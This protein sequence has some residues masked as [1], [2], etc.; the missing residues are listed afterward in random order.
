MDTPTFFAVA[1]IGFLSVN[2]VFGSELTVGK[3]SGLVKVRWTQGELTA[4]LETSATLENW[5]P[6]PVGQIVTDPAPD[7]RLYTV[8][9]PAG[10]RFF[11]LRLEDNSDPLSA[12]FED[13][14]DVSSPGLPPGWTSGSSSIGAGGTLWELGSPSSVGPS[15]ASS[16]P[17]CVGTDLDDQYEHNT[18]IWLRTPAIDLTETTFA[19][20]SFKRFRHIGANR[21]DGDAGSIRILAADN[22]EQLAL[23][24]TEV[25][26]AS[27]G[28]QDYSRELPPSAFAEPII[29]EFQFQSDATN[30]FWLGVENGGFEIPEDLGNGDFTYTA[31]GWNVSNGG[32]FDPDA[33]SGYPGG[34][35][36]EGENVAWV[37]NG[38][39]LTQNLGIQLSANTSY[40]LSTRIGTPNGNGGDRGTYR[41]ELRAGSEVIQSKQGAAPVGG[42]WQTQTIT[43]NSG[44]N[45]DQLDQDLEIRLLAVGNPEVNYDAVT[46]TITGEGAEAQADP[47]GWYLD[48]VQIRLETEGGWRV[49]TDSPVSPLWHHDDLFFIDDDTGWLCNISGEIWKT[50]DGG[51]SWTRVLSQPETAFRTIT[52]LD[53]MNGWV[54]NLGKG[55]WVGGVSD[56]NPLYETSDGGETW[57]AIPGNRISGPTPDGICGLWAV[58]ENTIHGTGR[59][60]GGAFFI[61]SRDGGATWVSRELSVDYRGFVDVF[62]HTPDVGYITGTDNSGDA[63][64]LYTADGGT[65]WTSAMSNNAIHYWKMGF[66]NETFGY[67]V[68]WSG[69]ESDRWIQT[70]DGGVTWTDRFFHSGVEA[71]GIGFV[72]EQTGWI[73]CDYPEPRTLETTDGGDSWHWIRIDPDYDDQINKFLQMGDVIY[74]VGYRVLKWTRP[75]PGPGAQ[76][77]KGAPAKGDGFDNS[78]CTISTKENSSPGGTSIT[79]TVPEDDRVQIT[80]CK[81]GGL[82]NYRPVDEYQTAGTYTIEFTANAETDPPALYAIIATG[83]YRQVVKFN[84]QP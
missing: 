21:S 8:G 52:F 19:T 36:P 80:I 2:P 37:Y 56:T 63:Q 1:L 3:E 20:L 71:N 34:N 58:G 61:S 49:L 51:D 11:R 29:V 41:L 38:G 10:S 7:G 14:D 67:G 6:V 4:Y 59:Y 42:S 62:F 33:S 70:Y 54:G 78:L 26:G 44:S 48:D 15:A 64:L 84:S 30:N 72:D 75:H 43:Y 23:L 5:Q 65:S 73:G 16:L 24:R 18:D 57:N 22:F 25:K 53:E 45:P 46:L 83:P 69:P 12:F 35:A 9:E 81:R 13:F 40:V 66:A 74:G 28:W 77:A 76:E 79:Y 55:G 27:D 17:N 39:A 60:D 47:A 68:T 50:I 82:I 32:V 31:D